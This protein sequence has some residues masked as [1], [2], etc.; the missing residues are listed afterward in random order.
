MLRQPAQLKKPPARVERRGLEQLAPG[1]AQGSMVVR[2]RESRV[3]YPVGI[4]AG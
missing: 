3:G 4:E 2:A 1:Q